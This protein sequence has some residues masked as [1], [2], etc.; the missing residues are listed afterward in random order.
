[1][2]RS[3]ENEEIANNTDNHIIALTRRQL[4]DYSRG[5]HDCIM[6]LAVD[7]ERRIEIDYCG[8]DIPRCE[9]ECPDLI[10]SDKT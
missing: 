5:L 6:C 7:C 8:G 4:A 3:K 10:R 9:P 1:M 2:E